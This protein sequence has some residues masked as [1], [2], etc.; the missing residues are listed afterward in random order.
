MC[1]N[2]SDYDVLRGS[3]DMRVLKI[4]A[5]VFS[6]AFLMAFFNACY[7]DNYNAQSAYKSEIEFL[8]DSQSISKKMYWLPK[9]AR[10]GI[11]VEMYKLKDCD[12]YASNYVGYTMK[13]YPGNIQPFYDALIYSDY[14]KVKAFLKSKKGIR[15]LKTHCVVYSCRTC[16]NYR[17]ERGVGY[18]GTLSS[19]YTPLKIAII[20]NDVAMIS[21][22]MDFYNKYG[23]DATFIT[24]QEGPHSVT[25]ISSFSM[26]ISAITFGD[27]AIVEFFLKITKDNEHKQK[28]LDVALTTA[29]YYERMQVIKMLVESGANV[30]QEANVENSLNTPL[31]HAVSS[32][33]YDIVEYLIQNG[34]DVNTNSFQPILM[35]LP[36][37]D[38]DDIIRIIKLLI[39]NGA[40]ISDV[41]FSVYAYYGALKTV[42][43]LLENGV[44][45]NLQ[46][47]EGANAILI[48]AQ[49]YCEMT[50]FGED[51]AHLHE[52]A[53]L[54]MKNGANPKLKD[55][56]GYSALSL[57]KECK[58]KEMIKILQG[59]Y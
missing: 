33:N 41:D 20:K 50:D 37:D 36:T 35:D 56:D 32:G 7:D 17:D 31:R 19:A 54:L 53:K 9:E 28:I 43:A 8:Q 1:Y 27:E 14:K 51:N 48:L 38:S 6:I 47:D 22:I 23:L 3:L 45:P 18:T 2:A 21:L 30:N 5:N 42:E 34:A 58:N 44:N 59:D 13:D 4:L 52:M 16:T 40:D 46:D 39:K 55:N 12:E 10:E 25:T 29:S 26:L 15:Y 24:K 11:F 49:V 57:A